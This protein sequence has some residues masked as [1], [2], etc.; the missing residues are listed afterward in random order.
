MHENRDKS[1]IKEK[2]FSSREVYKQALEG[3]LCERKPHDLRGT[4]SVFDCYC[5]NPSLLLPEK[6]VA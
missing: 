6:Q 4:K 3:E 5:A 2:A 1:K